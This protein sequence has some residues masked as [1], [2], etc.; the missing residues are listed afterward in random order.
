MS[1]T[2][3]PDPQK[4]WLRTVGANIRHERE[5]ADLT[6]ERLAEKADLATRTIQK[7]E[8]GQ[9]TIL[10]TTLRRIRKAIGCSYEALLKE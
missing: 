10:I 4:Q 3:N 1:K 6:Q 5:V 8:A 7:I 2:G 9:I